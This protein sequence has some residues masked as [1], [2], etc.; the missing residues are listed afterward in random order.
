MEENKVT[1]EKIQE[2]FNEIIAGSDEVFIEVQE[3]QEGEH[4]AFME[5]TQTEDRLLM[6]LDIH[7]E[8]FSITTN[9]DGRYIMSLVYELNQAIL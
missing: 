3:Y 2:A 9:M 6:A 1:A 5:M 7:G 4:Q 8:R